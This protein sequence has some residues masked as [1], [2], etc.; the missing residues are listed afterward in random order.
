MDL[1]PLA[2]VSTPTARARSA[3]PALRRLALVVLVALVATLL[4]ATAA[5]A[6]PRVPEAVRRL[7]AQP[8]DQS[9]T[10][11]WRAPADADAHRIRSYR[12]RVRAVVTPIERADA[13]PSGARVFGGAAIRL[14]QAPWQVAILQTG[15]EGVNAQFCGGSL[16]HPRWVL[17]AA[18][19][20]ERASPAAIQIGDGITDLDQV[21]PR[22]RIDVAR[23]ILHPRWNGVIGSGIDLALVELTRPARVTSVIPLDGR[24]AIPAGTEGFVSG[25]GHT[26]PNL[27]P[28]STG[29]RPRF[30]AELQ[31]ASVQVLAG[32]GDSCGLYGRAY[33]END[34]VCAAEPGVVDT[35]AGDSGGPLAL[36][37]DDQ[38]VLSG[39][40]SFGRGCGL[41]NYPGVYARVAPHVRWIHRHVDDLRGFGGTVPTRAAEIDGLTNGMTYRFTVAART[42]RGLGAPATITATPRR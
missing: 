7:R 9:V 15:R 41:E 34:H 40:T 17:T 3:R 35:C 8:E 5:G 42:P 10:L 12:I 4:P 11:R 20:V 28:D 31:G 33:D 18:H 22:Q 23:I 36:V 13:G 2:T 38:W 14:D 19:C 1:A 21:R 30:P 26:N 24:R 6:G 25:W 16:I 37:R 27:R 29:F 32:P 39:V